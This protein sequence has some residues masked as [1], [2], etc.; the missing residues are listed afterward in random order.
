MGHAMLLP[1]RDLVPTAEE[2]LLGLSSLSFLRRA[3]YRYMDLGEKESTKTSSSLTSQV[4]SSYTTGI[5][6]NGCQKLAEILAKSTHDTGGN[7]VLFR[8]L[9]K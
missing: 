7:I 1:V 4:R 5:L 8:F 6:H 2:F 9:A 3:V